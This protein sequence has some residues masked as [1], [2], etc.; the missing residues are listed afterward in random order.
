MLKHDLNNLFVNPQDED[1]VSLFRGLLRVMNQSNFGYV[2]EYHGNRGHV[3]HLMQYKHLTPR[4]RCCEI[5]DL[6]ML[7]IDEAGNMRYTFLQN[8]RDKKTKYNPGFPL[9]R[10]KADPVQWDLLHYRC[11]LS[12]PLST[13]L[14]IDCLSSAILNSAATYGIF[15]NEQFSGRVEMSY[16]I[17]RDMT[18]VSTGAITT[19]KYNRAYDLSTVYN[20]VN[21]VNGYWEIEGTATLDDFETAAKAMLIGTPVEID[22]PRHRTIAEIFLSFASTCLQDEREKFYGENYNENHERYYATISRCARRYEVNIDERIYLPYNLVLVESVIRYFATEERYMNDRMPIGCKAIFNDD[23]IYKKLEDKNAIVYIDSRMLDYE[24]Q[25]FLSLKGAKSK[26][27][28]VN[29]DQNGVK[30]INADCYKIII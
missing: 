20:R 30:L 9:R 5:A 3:Q 26:T 1:E 28:I 4:E 7:F 18:L 27:Y 19:R 15:L 25:K 13:N 14:P 21:F 24:L 22:N 2:K 8:K 12:D 16:N 11:Q 17:A 10:L 23:E 6:L 29:Y